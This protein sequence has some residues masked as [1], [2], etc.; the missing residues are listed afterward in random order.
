MK[1]IEVAAAFLFAAIAAFPAP[2]KTYTTIAA[3]VREDPSS[4]PVA[5]VDQAVAVPIADQWTLTAGLEYAAPADG[6][7]LS[8]PNRFGGRAGAT[9]TFPNGLYGETQLGAVRWFSDSGIDTTSLMAEAAI[10]AEGAIW[11]L[12]FRD[13]V[14]YNEESLVSILTAHGKWYPPSIR[15]EA[16]ASLAMEDGLGVSPSARGEIAIAP[17]KAVPYLFFGGGAGIEYYAIADSAGGGRGAETTGLALASLLFDSGSSLR[18]SAEKHFGDRN[19]DLW[20]FEVYFVAVVR[21]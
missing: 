11:Y 9:Y 21:P 17:F 8:D 20:R 16:K 7:F 19:D 3:D 18:F 5:G 1:R 4:V 2:V 10:N 12:G 6:S 15:S 14:L 13:R